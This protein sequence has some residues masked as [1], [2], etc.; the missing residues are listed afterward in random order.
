LKNEFN[1]INNRINSELNLLKVKKA[2]ISKY[3]LINKRHLKNKQIVDFVR[4]VENEL[5]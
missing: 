2:E 5:Q 4:Q 1:K 3:I